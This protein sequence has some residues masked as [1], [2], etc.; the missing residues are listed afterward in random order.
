MKTL[1]EGLGL[2]FGLEEREREKE[3]DYASIELYRVGPYGLYNM[4]RM[5]MRSG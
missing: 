1:Q 4:S 5:K 2:G 3:R